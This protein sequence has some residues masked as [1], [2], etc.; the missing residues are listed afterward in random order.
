ML[1]LLGLWRYGYKRFPFRYDPL[2]WGAVF[3]LGMY[4]A[5]TYEMNQAMG[6]KF[7]SYV[8]GIVYVLAL[9]AWGLT[10]LGMLKHGGR[11]VA[12]RGYAYADPRA[13]LI[14]TSEDR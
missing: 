14:K 8:P 1:L 2:Y 11:V 9:A 3:P 4:A 7:L 13:S 5:S 6:F 10:F 12:R